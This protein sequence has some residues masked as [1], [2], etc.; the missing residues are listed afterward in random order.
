MSTSILESFARLGFDPDHREDYI[1]AFRGVVD[2]LRQAPELLEKSDLP[3][4]T[5]GPLA[6]I[7][8]R[9]AEQERLLNVELWSLYEAA[10]AVPG[11][12]QE[13]W[14]VDVA[15]PVFKESMRSM[16]NAILE[17]AMELLVAIDALQDLRYELANGEL[18]V[19]RVS[20]SPEC[21]CAGCVDTPV[22]ERNC[23]DLESCDCA[24][25]THVRSMLVELKQQLTSNI[26]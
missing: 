19:G 25:C 23:R 13:H 10:D 3:P 11:P 2:A 8:A 22:Y 18:A 20:H 6:H 14:V 21:R 24:E 1:A 26:S 16:M 5:D 12:G 7:V 4:V 17:E 9:L 15:S